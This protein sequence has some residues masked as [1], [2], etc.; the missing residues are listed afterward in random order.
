MKE[1]M[2]V[3]NLRLPK[4]DWVLIKT[5]AAEAQMS[6]NEYLNYLINIISKARGLGVSLKKVPLKPRKRDS[7]WDL[8]HLAKGLKRKPMG[9]SPEDEIIYGI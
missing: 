2:V 9:L 4:S 1:E 7:I 6:L 8:P 5:L 3:T